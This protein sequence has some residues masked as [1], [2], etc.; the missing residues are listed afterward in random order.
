M[1]HLYN[2]KDKFLN[3]FND[4]SLKNKSYKIK[5]IPLDNLLKI[6]NI[7]QNILKDNQNI[8][9]KG[10][11]ALNKFVNNKIYTDHE[12]IYVDYDLYSYN[13]KND[14]IFIADQLFKNGFQEIYI[15]NTIYKE[16]IYRLLYLTNTI[17]DIE[18]IQENINIP[19]K[20]IDN[21]N[22][23][24]P[25]FQK[26]DMFSQL[27]RPT[28]VNV[29]N[30]DKV[31]N[32]IH[33]CN[34]LFPFIYSDNKLI[35]N[36]NNDNNILTNDIENINNIDI[37]DLVNMFDNDVVFTGHLAFSAIMYSKFMNDINSKF[38]PI[39]N[40][41]EVLVPAPHKYINKITEFYGSDRVIVQEMDNI[42]YFY[43]KFYKI[44]I[45]GH[46]KIIIWRL[47]ECCNFFEINNV[48]YTDYYY[49]LFHYSFSKFFS[50]IININDNFNHYDQLILELFNT[51]KYPDPIIRCFG[52]RN[53]GTKSLKN[54]FL[55]VDGLDKSKLF[56][57]N[58]S[59]NNNNNNNNND[60]NN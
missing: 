38:S 4:I 40:Y 37:Q 21:I 45:D 25:E 44:Y 47:D 1:S 41:L 3:Y 29:N 23:V 35:N 8:I 10:S 55:T 39:I 5:A 6:N 43:N 12:L 54:I 14:I 51:F 20:N 17:I 7:I 60:N 31:L 34:Q 11:R 22:Y 27:G 33:I 57:Y 24:I 59:S 26:I 49:L 15:R 56:R 28:L 48:K 52:E 36:N 30:W 58:P 42:L 2:N 19:H 9:V 53:P 32:R 50:Y 46:I 18:L 16:N 13:A